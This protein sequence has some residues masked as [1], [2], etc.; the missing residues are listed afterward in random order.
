[1]RDYIAEL[2]KDWLSRDG[3]TFVHKR[4]HGTLGW[5]KTLKPGQGYSA[6]LLDSPTQMDILKRAYPLAKNITIAMGTP[7][8]VDVK[9]CNNG[10]R[11]NGKTI[12]VATDVFNHDEIENGRKLDVFLGFTVHE[13]AHVLY[14][15]FLDR[16]YLDGLK[17][18]EA[19][20][21]KHIA[22]IIE[23]EYIERNIGDRKP[24]LAN[25]LEAAKWYAFGQY[26]E[27][28]GEKKP[29]PF[30][31]LVNA[32][33]GLVRY[34]KLLNDDLINRYGKYLLEARDVLTPYPACTSE[35]NTA[36]LKIFDIFKAFLDDS[37]KESL[38]ND[39][40]EPDDDVNSD[41]RTESIETDDDQLDC[42]DDTEVEI[43][44]GNDD[45]EASEN[46]ADENDKTKVIR[47]EFRTDEETEEE[48]GHISVSPR[49]QAKIDEAISR[50][51]EEELE[52]IEDTLDLAAPDANDG[53]DS[54]RNAD[55]LNSNRFNNEIAEGTLEEGDHKLVF[56]RN[57][58]ENRDQYEKDYNTIR[59]YVNDI[60][61]SIKSHFKEYRLIHHSQ[62]HGKLESR[63]LTEAYLGSKTTYVRKGEVQTDKIAVCV[64]VDESGSMG[65]KK[66]KAAR[67]TAILLNEALSGIPDIEL[68][69]YGH[70]GDQIS[71]GSTELIVYKD[72]KYNAPFAL[73]DIQS[74]Y[75]NRDG[76]AILEVARRVRKQTD[77]PVLM[78]IISDGSPSASNYRGM[79]AI[80]DT[81]EKVEQTEAMG[82]SPVQICI[83][84]DYDP[85]LMFKNFLYMT[86]IS[87][88]SLN[89]TKTIKDSLKHSTRT[90]LR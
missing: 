69:I 51:L 19:R 63:K 52:K 87:K 55:V 67:Q 65:Y 24:G 39:N 2:S 7:R 14:T 89:L 6:Y 46:D 73:G 76:M 43:S 34:P 90:H 58:I 62:K 77:R 36:A 23:D 78:F 44:F 64:L 61:K 41:S 68:F 5:E 12:Y 45:E 22:N 18:S 31:E 4:N 88:L 37:A 15:D 38:A 16:E 57:G 3:S 70:T 74:R 27:S 66:S 33:L 53:T 71:I 10:S 82:I 72:K 9:L 60:R 1:M 59:P 42:D 32:F 8:G 25:F 21:V 30:I 17:S 11:T 86:D 48:T 20:W 50:L 26:T 84:A 35:C 13:G 54:D 75:E 81:R 49:L 47:I 85:A 56:F 83:E 79:S 80:R 29:E 28:Y 40:K